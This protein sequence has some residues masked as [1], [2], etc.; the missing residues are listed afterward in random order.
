MI[1]GGLHVGLQMPEGGSIPS[2]NQNNDTRDLRPRRPNC[3][4]RRE[5]ERARERER[6]RGLSLSARRP[7]ERVIPPPP[8]THS[9]KSGDSASF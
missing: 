3:R 2:T 4:A 6:I 9:G 1:V 8:H 7:A 5:S